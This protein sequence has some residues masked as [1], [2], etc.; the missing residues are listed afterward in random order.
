MQITQAQILSNYA[1]AESPNAARS[2]SDETDTER[3]H[4][5]RRQITVEYTLGEIVDRL[6]LFPTL[7][8]G[9]LLERR[10][11]SE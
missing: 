10:T 6:Y 11:H 7:A 4:D 2:A 1:P 5:P 9:R 8:S 3:C